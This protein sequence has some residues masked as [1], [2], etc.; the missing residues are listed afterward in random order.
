[1]VRLSQERSRSRDGPLP[2]WGVGPCPP[3]RQHLPPERR[4][5]RWP[6]RRAREPDEEEAQARVRFIVALLL[7]GETRFSANG[8]VCCRDCGSTYLKDTFF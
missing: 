1:M 4:R 7:S 3:W 8:W 5:A 2:P 6:A